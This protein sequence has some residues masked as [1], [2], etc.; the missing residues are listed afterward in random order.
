MTRW[1]KE[2]DRFHIIG[3]YE[4]WIRL[5]VEDE[6]ELHFR[7]RQHHTTQTFISHPTDAFQLVL[8]QQSCIY[9]YFQNSNFIFTKITIY[10]NLRNSK[11]QKLRIFGVL[12]F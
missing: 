6:M 4:L 1:R 7:M 2:Y 3:E 5:S 12:N 9:S 8:K 10:L 11:S